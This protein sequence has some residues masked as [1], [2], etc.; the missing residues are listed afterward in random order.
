MNKLEIHTY[1]YSKAGFEL[2][3]VIIRADTP[4]EL[5]ALL[6]GLAKNGITAVPPDPAEL[7]GEKTETITCVMKRMHVAKDG[8]ETPVVDLYPSWQGEYGQYRFVG[9]YLNTAEQITEFEQHSG[10]KLANMPE[11]ESQAPLQR[12]ANRRHKCEIACTPFGVRKLPDGVKEIDGKQQTVWKFAGYAETGQSGNGSQPASPPEQKPAASSNGNTV[13]VWWK[14][15]IDTVKPLPHFGGQ[16]KHVM[17]ALNKM[18]GDGEID[19]SW[20]AG[21]VI[22]AVKAKYDTDDAAATEYDENS[23]P[24]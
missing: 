4:E 1:G 2:P 17:N 18:I 23:I 12:N 8:R 22:E 9:L 7:T 13:P 16:P 24:F 6:A 14:Q 5:A 3:Q 19:V 11:Y 10:L 20:N 21:K 15:V